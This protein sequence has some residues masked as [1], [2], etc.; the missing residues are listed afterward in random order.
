MLWA[1]CGR[2]RAFKLTAQA[3][4]RGELVALFPGSQPA[5]RRNLALSQT[6]TRD[7]TSDSNLHRCAVWPTNTSRPRSA[8]VKLLLCSLCSTTS[9]GQLSSARTL[10]SPSTSRQCEMADEVAKA[11]AAAVKGHDGGDTIF[12]KI[13]RREIKADI[14]Y[15]SPSTIDLAR[16]SLS[17]D[18]TACPT[19]ATLM[20]G[21]RSQP[22]LSPAAPPCRPTSHAH[23]HAGLIL[24]HDRCSF[25]QPCMCLSTAFMH[26]C[27][28]MHALFPSVHVCA[29]H[30]R[31][32][33]C[34]NAVHVCAPHDRQRDC[35]SA[36]A[37]PSTRARKTA[38]K[39]DSLR[40]CAICSIRDVDISHV[41]A[42]LHRTRTSSCMLPRNLFSIHIT[43]CQPYGPSSNTH[44]LHAL[45][46]KV[47][48]PRSVSSMPFH[49]RPCTHSHQR[50]EDEVCLAFRDINPQAPVHLLVI[51]KKKIDQLSRAKPEDAPILGH[52]LATAGKLGREHC[53]AGFRTV[54]NDGKNGAQS[55][56]HLHVHVLG[57]RQ[58]LWPP[59]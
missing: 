16:G 3:C 42:H 34:V 1:G 33:D 47:P 12:G 30:D 25:M 57:G 54:I 8:A 24:M 27:T 17:S 14:V 11:A 48:H 9:S 6:F 51:P 52:L 35:V 2:Y 10:A 37:Q 20:Q 43:V 58:M 7:H 22:C 38:A 40:H 21:Q 46:A 44:A 53:A 50:Y 45:S 31:Q 41:P 59:G 36:D 5:D 55:V 29:P 19:Q 4:G 23:H 32:R 56:Y 18:K 39:S 13:I 26:R 28:R 15:V 49:G